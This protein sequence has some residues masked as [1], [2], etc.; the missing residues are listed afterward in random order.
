MQALI[1]GAADGIGRA[2]AEQCVRKGYAVLGVDVDEERS[3]Q[4]ATQ[5]RSLGGEV[6][7]I[8]ADLSQPTEVD[9]LVSMLA[10]RPAIDLLVHNAGINAV[11]RF[12]EIP[13]ERQSAVIAINL[14]APM[15]ITAGLLQ[16][17]QLQAGGSVVFLSSLSHYVS[18]P[19]AAVYAATKDGLASY[20]R[21]LRVALSP[22][23]IHVLTVF[24]GP[25]RTA[26]ARRY[27][28][29]NSREARRMPPEELARQILAAVERRQWT[30]IPGPTNK[31][32]AVLGRLLPGSVERIMRRTLLEKL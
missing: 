9:H 7:F 12:G 2:L 29:D 17:K 19:G 1:T 22:Q 21:S 25:T 18:Y 20:A 31:L 30:L 26:H 5:L 28:P 8:T 14:T 6:D 15:V 16:A 4:T 27:S 24:P 13:F 23:Q 10:S 11:G 3:A 32:F